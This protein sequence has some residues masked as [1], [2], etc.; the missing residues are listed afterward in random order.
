MFAEIVS[1]LALGYLLWSIIAM[2][3]NHRRASKMGIPLIR[4][5]VDP[6][7]KIWLI[8][9]PFLWRLLDQLPI[10]FGNFGHYSRR[11]W[12]FH[13]KATSHSK[14]GPIF[15]LVT[16]CDI[17]VYVADPDAIHE[18]FTRRRDF[19][20][21]SKMYTLL[22]VYGPCI[23]TANWTNWPRHRKV[24]AAPFNENVMEFVWQESLKRAK[25]MLQKWNHRS[26]SQEISTAK[27]MRT[28]SLNVI[29]ATG[30]RK[31]YQFRS[32]VQAGTDEAGSYRDALQT[33]L[34]NVILIMFIPFRYLCLPFMPKSWRLVGKAAA[35][36][37]VYMENMLDEESSLLREGKV[38][39]GTLMT[40]FVRALEVHQ[41]EEIVPSRQTAQS[42][43]KGLTVEEIFG[44]VF[45]I[46]FAGHDTTANTLAFSMILLAAH[47]EV[48]DWV[49][50]EL[51]E[52]IKDA[53]GKLLE[54]EKVFEKLNRCRAILLETLRQFPP[55]MALPKWSNEIPQT[56]QIQGKTIVIPPHTGVMPSTSFPRSDGPQNCPGQK[57]SQVEFVAVLAIL[58]RHHRVSIVQGD[59]KTPEKAKDRALTVTQD[60]DMELLLRMRD[61]DQSRGNY[62]PGYRPP[63]PNPYANQNAPVYDYSSGQ[64]YYPQPQ[65]W[66]TPSP[67]GGWQPQ[68]YQQPYG[69]PDPNRTWQPQGPQPLNRDQQRAAARKVLLQ[70]GNCSRIGHE[71]KR[72]V[73]PVNVFGVIDGCPMR[74]TTDHVLF[75]C[76]KAWKSEVWQALSAE[77]RP[78]IWTPSFALQYQLENPHYWRDYIYA[79]TWQEEPPLAQD[80][81]WENPSLVIYLKDRSERG[82]TRNASGLSRRPQSQLP[83]PLAQYF[84]PTTMPQ[85]PSYASF[86]PP[87]PPP[88]QP[89]RSTPA[90]SPDTFTL[91]GLESFTKIAQNLMILAPAGG[92]NGRGRK[93]PAI[94][95]ASNAKVKDRTQRPKAQTETETYRERSPLRTSS[96]KLEDPMS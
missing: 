78:K 40:S 84:P 87:P 7:N 70:C 27:D 67:N 36:F 61:A 24:L 53:A 11:G 93:K 80:P 48:Q 54:Y 25:E 68:G 73:G 17:Y 89:P 8:L 82:L 31:S 55:I 9:E 38:A 10:N 39:S 95:A 1:G 85:F 43:S 49:A 66:P 79:R 86:P 46:N 26:E 3:I 34:D 14:Y 29:A 20:R 75:E 59:N 69:T 81:A 50:E 57:S 6:M 83:P 74:N 88:S 60:C 76:V 47:P 22:E 15:G 91:A 58:L 30:F 32:S 92:N 71:L 51:Q 44:D 56:L 37:K 96:V 16:P 62:P 13:N 63:N 65:P 72:C 5:P 18:T 90:S 41:K 52:A 28:L 77:T 21:P 64:Y 45:V 4:L 94:K 19:L 12:H 2:E 23:S 33:V 42:P 35:D